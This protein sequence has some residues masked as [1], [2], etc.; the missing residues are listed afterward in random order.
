MY[1]FES[2]RSGEKKKDHYEIKIYFI[3]CLSL[4]KKKKENEKRQQV[5]GK[6]M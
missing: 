6:Y 5:N 1:L 2:G 3:I 4:Q